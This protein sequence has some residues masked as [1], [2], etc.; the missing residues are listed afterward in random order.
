[1]RRLSI[2]EGIKM[3][4]TKEVST[5]APR[6]IVTSIILSIII[7][8]LGHIY[9]G[10]LILGILIFFLGHLFAFIF[11][12]IGIWKSTTGLFLI[13]ILSAIYVLAVIIHSVILAKVNKDYQLKSYNRFI[14]YALCIL[15]VLGLSYIYEY[16]QVHRAKAYRVFTSSMEPTTRVGDYMLADLWAFKKSNPEPG[17]IVLFKYP[18]EKDQVRFDRCI[19]TGGQTLEII[20]KIVYVNGERFP[21]S[22]K[23][24]FIDQIIFPKDKNRF[25]QK[26]FQNLGTRDNFG[27]IVI[28]ENAYWVMGDNRDSSADSRYWGF[29]PHDHLMGKAE[30]IY[31]SLDRDVPWY[32]LFKKIRWDRIGKKLE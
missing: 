29:V 4:E 28:P 12:A 5:F 9:N 3:E 14:Y 7:P 30:I 25:G 16:F 8:G 26:T 27:P 24:Q 13:I 17:D 10:K 11:F 23:V 2:F 31:F 18:L 22:A 21:D 20:D 19:A 6:G 15:I 32:K 1:M